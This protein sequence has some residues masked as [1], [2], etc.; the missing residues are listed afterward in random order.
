[1]PPF[2]RVE[3]HVL[4]QPQAL[5]QEIAK[6]RMKKMTITVSSVPDF[7]LPEFTTVVSTASLALQLS[8]LFS[9]LH[10]EQQSSS[11]LL[12][13]RF[14]ERSQP[15]WCASIATLNPVADLGLIAE[16]TLSAVYLCHA[17]T[18]YNAGPDKTS[19]SFFA[20]TDEPFDVG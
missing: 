12:G 4:P 17:F 13:F 10:C 15:L 19:E 6:L 5:N 8:S 18:S 11:C 9:P 2:A 3:S 14:E 20:S 1:M 16:I 7:Q